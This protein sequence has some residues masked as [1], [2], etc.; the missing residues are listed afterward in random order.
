MYQLVDHLLYSTLTIIILWVGLAILFVLG[1][2]RE[3]CEVIA[4]GTLL[5]YLIP[6]PGLASQNNSYY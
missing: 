4:A 3:T 2:D 6:S 1:L 5:I